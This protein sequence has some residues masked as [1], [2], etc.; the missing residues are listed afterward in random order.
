MNDVNTAD[1]LRNYYGTQRVHV[2]HWKSLWHFLLDTTITNAYKLTHCTSERPYAWGSKHS[3]HSRFRTELANELFAHSER[4]H[5]Q[6]SCHVKPKP[7]TEKIKPA[8]ISSHEPI[9]LST[10]TRDYCVSCVATGRVD[11]SRIQAR[12]ALNELNINSL[13]DGARRKRAPLMFH[14]C[15]LCKLY[16]CDNRECWQEHIVAK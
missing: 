12:K 14:G 6:R 13:A 2:K 16:I 3:S 1:Q 5:P 11:K 10:K 15:E 4:L 9:K 8:P 7:L